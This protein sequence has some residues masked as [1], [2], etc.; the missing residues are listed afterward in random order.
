VSY[1]FT[2]WV[3]APRRITVDG[4]SIRLGGFNFQHP[5]TVDVIGP[6]EPRVTLLVIPPE[7][8]QMAAHQV[9]MTASRRDNA[10]NIGELLNDEPVRTVRIP[11]QR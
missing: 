2:D 5:H 10:D 1:H 7:T 11:R 4:R 9:L 3:A 6:T 8:E